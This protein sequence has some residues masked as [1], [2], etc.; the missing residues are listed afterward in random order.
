MLLFNIDELLEDKDNAL[1][2]LVKDLEK[3]KEE[4][5]SRISNL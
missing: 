1:P 5:E 4:L 2:W 3:R